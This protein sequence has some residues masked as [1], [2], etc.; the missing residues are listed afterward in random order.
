MQVQL[1][2][3]S[4]VLVEFAVEVEIERVRNEFDKTFADLAKGAKVKGFR[5]G[6]APRRVLL[7]MFG[8]RVAA[9]VAK[10]LVDETF[11]QAVSQ[12]AI[13]PVSAPAVEQAKLERDKPF[14]YKA[15]VEVIPEVA[16][17]KYEGLTAKR[18]SVEATEEQ[19]DKELEGLR[20]AFSTLEPLERPRPIESGDVVMVDFSVE[21]E[22]KDVP[23][24]GAQ[25]FQAEVGSGTLLS[26]IE[27]ALLGK[28]VGQEAVAEIEMPPAHPA[29]ALR[30]RLAKFTLNVK[31]VKRRVLPELDDEFAKDA[32][33]YETLEELK[34][35]LKERVERTLKEQ[36]ENKVAEQLVVELVKKNPIPIPNA[37]VEQQMR[38][39][40]KEVL[41]QARAAGQPIAQGLGEELRSRIR[42]DSEVKVRA[43]LLMAAIAKAEGIK[44][45]EKQIEEGLNE[46]AEQTGKALAKLKA[47]YRPPEKRQMLIGMILEN[48]VLDLIE[49]KAQIEPA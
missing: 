42:V 1:N 18:P 20:R 41:A 27:E 32:G 23:E 29:R 36:M 3:L 6:K 9:D 5:P 26:G 2:K 12:Q 47:E 28:Q 40:E 22:G 45:G 44:I 35:H 19:I 46:L 38:L 30:G 25:D 4:P 21:A 11:P 24:A 14:T 7:H 15:R 8:N 10:R 43:G 31:D 13:Q 16:E 33:D 39:T 49:S 37:L 34:Q 48:K 17:V